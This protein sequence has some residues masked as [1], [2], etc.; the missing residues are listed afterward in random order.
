MLA[1]DIM[2][3][4]VAFVGGEA[5]LRDVARLLLGK[6]IS[7]VP[8]VDAELRPIG[9]VSEGDLAATS[10]LNRDARAQ[11][12]LAQLAEGEPLDRRFLETIQMNNRAVC[13]VMTSPVICVAET[14]EAE[15]IARIMEKCKIKR[16]IVTTAGKMVGVVSRAD[17]VRAV[18]AERDAPS[19]APIVAEDGKVLAR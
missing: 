14:T 7:A 16:V 13:D 9:I 3:K 5:R 8:V 6:S 2:T 12:W 15:E 10:E 1:K 17:I 4:D 11:W 18:A 19:R